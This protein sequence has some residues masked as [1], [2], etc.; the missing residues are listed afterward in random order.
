[1]PRPPLEASGTSGMKNAVN[2]GLQLSVLDGWW[3]EGY[4][5]HNGWAI[6][7]EVDDDHGGQDARDAAE[8][9]R[10]IEEEVVPEFH[11]RDAGGVPQ[12]WVARV[13]RS[14][15]TNIPR[16]STTRMMRDY[17]QQIYRT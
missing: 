12:A 3:V 15:R 1:V 16:F 5:G 4:D 2:G 8:L 17:E 11:D 10:L 6:S 9:Y 7:G 14:M 13:K